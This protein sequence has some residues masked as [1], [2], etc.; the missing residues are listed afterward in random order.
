MLRTVPSRFVAGVPGSPVG[1]IRH[2]AA[3]RA[4]ALPPAQSWGEIVEIGL[5]TTVVLVAMDFI[6]FREFGS[7]LGMGLAW[8][9]STFE[10]NSEWFRRR[11][12]RFH[13]S[14][15]RWRAGRPHERWH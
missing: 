9:A 11:V 8:T 1:P 5:F 12:D 13:R 15:S 3:S 10:A 6:V 14:T 4:A 7:G 2:R